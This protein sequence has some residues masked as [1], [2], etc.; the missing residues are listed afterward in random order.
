MIFI[1]LALII[2]FCSFII[3]FGLGMLITMAHYEARIKQDEW[4]APD[5]Q[6]YLEREVIKSLLKPKTSK[7]K[8]L[9]SQKEKIKKYEKRPLVV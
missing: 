1:L 8:I 6:E 2:F 4:V 9:K 3:G 7:P 5:E